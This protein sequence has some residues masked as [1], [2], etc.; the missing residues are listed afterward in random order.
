MSNI[1]WI[2][3]SLNCGTGGA[4]KTD[5]FLLHPTTLILA[6]RRAYSSYW[7]SR[8]RAASSPWRREAPSLDPMSRRTR[9][10][11]RR[12]MRI[13]VRFLK[14][15]FILMCARHLTVTRQ[16]SYLSIFSAS[17]WL[18]RD[19]KYETFRDLWIPLTMREQGQRR[20][21]ARKEW[22]RIDD[23]I[24]INCKRVCKI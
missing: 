1:F 2:I 15:I 7:S 11:A 23:S 19:F 9:E 10:G 17:H 8:R 3:C 12:R 24:H 21:Q 22:P 6:K 4:E 13:S 5:G 18:T 14:N 16:K 20:L